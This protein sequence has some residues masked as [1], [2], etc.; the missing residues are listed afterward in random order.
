MGRGLSYAQKRYPLC[1][2]LGHIAK[3]ISHQTRRA[4]ER[5]VRSNTVR[6]PICR[7]VRPK[8]FEPFNHLYRNLDWLEEQHARQEIH[9]SRDSKLTR[10]RTE[11]QRQ[12]EYLAEHPRA[13]AM[14]ALQKVQAK[15][16]QLKIS[17][18]VKIEEKDRQIDI[19]VDS[20]ALAATSK[21]DGCYVLKTDLTAS[22]CAKEVVHAR[23]KAL[24]LYV[25]PFVNN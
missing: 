23:Y 19:R 14:V 1:V 9:S 2:D 4:F 13:K 3:L 17:E 7:G 8:R 10:V 6:L 11:A 15:A 16:K 22:Q 5:R 24:A 18:W 20:E 25:P 21:L 12:T